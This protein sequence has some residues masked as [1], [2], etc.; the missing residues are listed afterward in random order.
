MRKFYNKSKGMPTQ[1][2]HKDVFSWPNADFLS[3]TSTELVDWWGNRVDKGGNRIVRFN[4]RHWFVKCKPN[5][6]EQKR[7]FLAYILGHGWTNI[8]EVLPLSKAEFDG[9]R[10]IGIVLPRWATMNNTYL[11]RLVADY[12]IDQLPH[13]DLNRAVASEIVFSLWIRRRD[14]HAANRAYIDCIPVFFDHQTAFLGEPRLSDINVFFELGRDAGYAGRWR[15]ELVNTESIISTTEMRRMGLERDIALHLVR[16][17]LNF[18]NCIEEVA[19]HVRSDSPRRWR[20][21][22]RT[23]GYSKAHAEEITAFLERN[24]GALGAEIEKMRKVIFQY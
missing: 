14:T 5:P 17:Y 1:G 13:A 4:E 2:F 18:N 23:A 20:Q 3:A 19:Q 15:V 22:A 21:A 10:R 24:R 16:D 11:V 12:T 8:A 6:E 9:L 7:D